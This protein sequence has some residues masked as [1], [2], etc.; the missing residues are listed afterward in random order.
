MS[1]K[2]QFKE[3]IKRD[4]ELIRSLTTQNEILERELEEAKNILYKRVIQ[5]ENSGVIKKKW[6]QFWK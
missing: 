2:Q 3:V 6:Y 1:S 5:Q 4:K